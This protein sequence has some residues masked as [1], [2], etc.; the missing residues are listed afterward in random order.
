MLV[1]LR[2]FY[3]SKKAIKLSSVDVGKVVVSNNIKGKMGPVNILLVIL[4]MLTILSLLYV[5]LYHK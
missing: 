4:M 1:T 2:E 3:D 5:L